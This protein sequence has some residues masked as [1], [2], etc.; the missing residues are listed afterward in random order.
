MTLQPNGMHTSPTRPICVDYHTAL[1]AYYLY[2]WVG[3]DPRDGLPQEAARV[4]SHYE[5]DLW[6]KGRLKKLRQRLEEDGVVLPQVEANG[7]L[8]KIRRFIGRN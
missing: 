1:K 6:K 2:V 8:G 7:L 5:V 3:Y 4:A